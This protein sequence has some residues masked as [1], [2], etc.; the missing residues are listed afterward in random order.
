MSEG[1]GPCQDCGGANIVWFT[2]S[3][4]WNE[5]MGNSGGLLCVACF[6]KRA[7]VRFTP[8]GWRV[9]PEWSWQE[10]PTTE[11]GSR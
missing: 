6:V 10:I 2:D 3:V 9:L 1:D 4:F 7:E 5:V 8:T 11:G